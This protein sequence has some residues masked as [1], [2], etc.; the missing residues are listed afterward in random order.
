M[1]KQ[2]RKSP[3][4][5][6]DFVCA[7]GFGSGLSKYAPGT[8]G[9]LAAVPLIWALSFL[10]FVLYLILVI[11]GFIIGIGICTR[12]SARLGAKD[13]SSIVWDEIVGFAIAMSLSPRHLILWTIGFILFRFFDIV[14][15]W[16]IKLLE[17]KYKNG[18]G[19]ML[20]DAVA[21]FFT[22]LILQVIEMYV[23]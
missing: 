10:P 1:T 11:T 13:P 9:T 12:V 7:H 15:P 6:I 4:E 17:A 20:D 3:G 18:F 23:I 19:I 16:P 2:T 8:I 22:L 14:K 21:G 5:F